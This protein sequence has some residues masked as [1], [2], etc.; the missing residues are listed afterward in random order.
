MSEAGDLKYPRLFAAAGLPD[1]LA[2]YRARYAADPARVPILSVWPSFLAYDRIQDALVDR[3]LADDDFD[4]FLAYSRFPDVF[5]HFATLFLERDYHDRVDGFVGASAEPTAEVLEE[6]N[7]NLADV[8]APLL[9]HKE[10]LI[11]KLL[12]RARAEGAYLLVVSDHGFRMS[13]KGYTHYGLAEGD[14]PDGILALCGPGVKPGLR[15]EADV[16]DVAPTVLYLKGLPVGSDMDGRPLIDALERPWPVR[17][18]VYARMRHQKGTGGR[19][20][21]EKK[22]EE[23]RSL[24]YIK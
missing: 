11:A 6:F 19:E 23:L 13:T 20:L 1:Y 17:T 16:Y 3:Y 10:T 9:R 2:E 15:I 12:A 8:A 5:F 18:T 21:D 4:L 7:W 14:P 22:L 24:G